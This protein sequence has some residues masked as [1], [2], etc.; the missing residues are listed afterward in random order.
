VRC[1]VRWRASSNLARKR[2]VTWIE[3]WAQVY[4]EMLGLVAH[5]ERVG[6]LSTHP[7]RKMQALPACVTSLFA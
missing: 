7:A 5:A 6:S 2:G 1:W 4:D 3:V